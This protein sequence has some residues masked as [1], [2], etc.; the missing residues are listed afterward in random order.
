[1]ARYMIIHSP[2]GALQRIL[3]TLDLPEILPRPEADIVSDEL[4]RI[5][6]TMPTHEIIFRKCDYETNYHSKRIARH[7]LNRG[8]RA[9][10]KVVP[11]LFAWYEKGDKYIETNENIVSGA[12][13]QLS[14]LK[15]NIEEIPEFVEPVS[16]HMQVFGHK[17]RNA[18]LVACM[19]F[20]NQCRGVLEANGITSGRFTTNDYVKL[21][22][23]MRLSQY[24][25]R[26]TNYPMIPPFRPFVS[27]NLAQP[28]QSLQWYNDYNS[29]KHG[30]DANFDRATLGTLLNSI[31]AVAI[32]IVAQYRTI[33]SWSDRFGD[34]FNFVAFPAWELWEC[35]SKDLPPSSENWIHRDFVF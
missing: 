26:F 12:L 7:V 18:L 32:M 27:W 16:S 31:A 24:E 23:P 22:V 1:M 6:N 11:P 14:I 29:T 15:R 9:D 5:G 33:P 25:L 30:R 3:S 8:R 20:E 19:E 2:P 17:S 34:F 35:Y 4:S 10:A 21:C 28:T 13:T